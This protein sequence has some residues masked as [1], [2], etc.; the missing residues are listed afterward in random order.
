MEFRLSALAPGYPQIF[1][2]VQS[3]TSGIAG[4]LDGYIL[5]VN[6]SS[7][8]AVLGRQRADNFVEA[9]ANVTI[10]PGLNTNDLY[11][12]RLRAEGTAAVDLTATFERWTGSTWVVIGQATATDA[13][14]NRIS[15]AGAVGF[16]GFVESNYAF[17]NFSVTDLDQ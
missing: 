1:S 14:A 5:Y 17:D 2:R 15:T 11:R 3:A 4:Q 12:M 6:N 13:A 16:G 9:L 8:D 7:G 10:A